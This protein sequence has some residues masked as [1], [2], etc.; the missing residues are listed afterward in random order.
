MYRSR[1]ITNESAR[2]LRGLGYSADRMRLLRE[3][4]PVTYEHHG[5]LII[6]YPSGRRLMVTMEREY[7]AH[8]AFTA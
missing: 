4:L 6:K 7:H 2:K 8:G 3:S 5:D 1:G